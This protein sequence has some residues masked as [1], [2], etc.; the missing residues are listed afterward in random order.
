MR[1]IEVAAAAKLESKHLPLPDS[2]VLLQMPELPGKA[3]GEGFEHCC[4]PKGSRCCE[5]IS[6]KYF[7]VAC[8]SLRVIIFWEQRAGD[9]GD[10]Q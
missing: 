10:G 7:G 2:E 3:A 9:K 8:C 5:N 1:A 4:C 6:L